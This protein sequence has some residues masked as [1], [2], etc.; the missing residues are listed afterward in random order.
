M[1]LRPGERQ[2]SMI[3]PNVEEFVP[4]EHRYRKLLKLVDWVELARP[5]RNLYS[6]I[7][8]RGYPTEQGLKCL[9]LQFLEDRSDRQMERLLQDSLAA[10]YF[11]NFGLRD[12][13]PDHSYFGKFR[14]KVGVYRLSQIFKRITI[15]LQNKE[16]Y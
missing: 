4:A 7:G 5:L 15:L 8:R 1:A 12:E 13:I 2:M 3:V 6:D 14:E 10:K 16:R 11:C 9:F